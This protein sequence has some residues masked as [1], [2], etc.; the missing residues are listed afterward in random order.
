MQKL[1]SK[2]NKFFIILIAQCGKTEID[3]NGVFNP[4]NNPTNV[5]NTKIKS[6]QKEVNIYYEYIQF[7]RAHFDCTNVEYN[8]NTGRISY[9]EFK[10]NGTIS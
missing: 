3:V 2:K 1:K 9:M 4:P 10:F 7:T 8:P 5:Y 6:K